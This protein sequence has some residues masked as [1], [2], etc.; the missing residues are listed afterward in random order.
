MKNRLIFRSRSLIPLLLVLSILALSVT[1]ALAMDQLERKLALR[2]DYSFNSVTTQSEQTKRIVQALQHP[3]HA[4][5]I[6]T[7]GME[8]QAL[9][10]LLNRMAALSPNFT[11]TVTSLVESPML[12]NTL[13]SKLQDD[14]VTADSLVL[15]CEATG[16]ARVLNM[17][18]YLSQE[19]DMDRQAYVLSGISYEKSI[20]EALL[21]ITLKEVPRVK[22]L[23]G[24]GEIAQ[25]DTSHMESFLKNHHFEVSRVNL[26]SGGTL[27]PDDLLMILSPQIDLM[28]EELQI[29]RDFTMK[30]GA[31]L[32]TSDYKDP[33]KL[34]NLDALYRQMGFERLPGIVVAE[35]EDKQAYV[36]NPLFLTPYMDMT[37]PT[38]ALIGAGQTRLQLPGARAM[39]IA[40]TS[41]SSKVDPLLTS[42]I[43]YIKSVPQANQ[44]LSKSEG[45]PEGQFHLALLSDYSVQDGTRARAMIIGNSAILLDSWLH[46]I[47]YGSQFLLHMVNHLSSGNPI[48]LDIAPKT[49]VREQ[50][51]MDKPWLA[52][53]IL[54]ALPLTV[55]LTAVPVLIL[56]KR[57]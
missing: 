37:E 29:L 6:F 52:N 28:D 25:N 50:L 43:A 8:D 48:Q 57:R 13:S 9:T 23:T 2:L 46:Q 56:R 14:Q 54:L 35:A 53:L 45:D 17:Y 27:E 4:Y 24:H 32:I 7:P 49:L 41:T 38:A 18:N 12:V 19:F 33:D 5:A 47:S 16:R 22:I 55:V 51:R 31:V 21:Y 15:V 34:P 42:G 40:S 11:Y 36:D 20:A 26:M 30:G 1:A 39:K 3:V 44:S 10:G